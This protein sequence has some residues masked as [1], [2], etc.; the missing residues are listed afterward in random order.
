MRMNK[1]K[2]SLLRDKAGSMYIDLLI[3]IMVIVVFVAVFVTM[4][5]VFALSQELNQTARMT[6]RIVEVTGRVGDEVDEVL[7]NSHNMEPDTVEWIVTYED[8]IEG[9]IQL[10]DTFTV[11]LTK[12]V[13]ITII[14]PALGDP[15][16]IVI[17]L[18]ADASGVSEV[19]WK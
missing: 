2:N 15:L 11:V 10:K 12:Q 8:K 6:A 19:Y 4:Y 16:Q 7:H 1:R 17:T 13:P 9:T 5:P 14:K 3:G 18:K